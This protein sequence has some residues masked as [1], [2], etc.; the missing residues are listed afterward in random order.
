MTANVPEPSSMTGNA[1]AFVVRILLLT[2][3]TASL[4]VVVPVW[5]KDKPNR[6]FH[7]CAACPEMV[8][9]P[10]GRFTMGVPPGEEEREGVP[11]PR[12]GRSTPQHR[13]SIGHAFAIGKFDVTRAEFATFISATGYQTGDSKCVVLHKVDDRWKSD[14]QPGYSW[15]DPG[16][17]QT[18]QHPVVCVSWDDAKAYVAWL[19]RRTGYTYRLPTEAEWEYAARAGSQAPRFWGEDRE[20]I[21]AYANVADVTNASTLNAPVGAKAQ[22]SD[23]YAFT[24][25]VGSFQPNQFGLYDMLGNV[26]QWQEDCWN[27][28]YQGA[29]SDGSAWTTGDCGK[30]VERGGA[31]DV[32]P[33]Y[34]RSGSRIRDDSV[35]RNSTF[36]FRVVRAR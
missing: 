21:C 13:V 18:D 23:G 7:D 2:A 24:A 17:P 12:Q 26:W 8:S 3:V 15:R 22:C 16:F 1:R 34:V 6:S 11:E 28:T 9:I 35:N 32:N 10:P 4:L 25:P 27:E 36:G 31:W 5:A 30:R 19:S 14:E 20:Q 33:R 29:P